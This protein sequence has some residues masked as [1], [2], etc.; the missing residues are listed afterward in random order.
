[1]QGRVRDAV[2]EGESVTARPNVSCF[3]CGG[4]GH[5]K[6]DCVRIVKSEIDTYCFNCEMRS[7]E[8]ID[9]TKEK[10]HKKTCYRCGKLGHISR[11]CTETIQNENKIICTY[12]KKNRDI[13]MK[14]VGLEIEKLEI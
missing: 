8:P 7:H 3:G 12:C 10:Y 1:M 6:K 2:R 11:F 9:C 5:L 13:N 14:I 4:S